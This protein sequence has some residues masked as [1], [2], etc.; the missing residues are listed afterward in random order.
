MLLGSSVPKPLGV[1]SQGFFIACYCTVDSVCETACHHPEASAVINH[2]RMHCYRQGV[3]W[4]VDVPKDRAK[5]RRV[6]LSR[7]GWVVTHSEHI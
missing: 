2:I 1:R 5:D 7:E 4:L 6:E 3:F